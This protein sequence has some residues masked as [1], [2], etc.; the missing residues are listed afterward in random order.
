MLDK[1]RKEQSLS[2]ISA[3]VK[4]IIDEYPSGH[5]FFG[6]QLKDDC[7]KIIPEEKDAYVE[8][9]LRMMRRHRHFSYRVVDQNNSLYE[10][11]QE[12]SAEPL[13]RYAQPLQQIEFNF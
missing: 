6:N 9:F 4:L 8:T 12:V 1:Q 11:V 2:T 5:Q 10:K 3:A 13:F 7:I